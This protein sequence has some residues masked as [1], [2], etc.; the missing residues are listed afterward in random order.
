MQ[1]YSVPSG[2]YLTGAQ[3][4]VENV[5]NIYDTAVQTGFKVDDVIKQSNANDAVKKAASARRNASVAKQAT[6]S[7][8]NL[9]QSD[10][11]EKASKKIDET[12]RPAKRMAG[13]AAATTS[14][15]Q[16]YLQMQENKLRQKEQAEIR[17]EQKRVNDAIIA[18]EEARRK[19]AEADR[20]LTEKKLAE[21]NG[22][23]SDLLSKSDN[24]SSLS[25]TPSVSSTTSRLFQPIEF[26]GSGRLS[27]EQVKTLALNSGF[28]DAESDIVVKIAR[29][30][31]SFNPK[32]HNDD[33]S[34]GDNSFG[35]MQINMLGNLGPAR[36]KQFGIESNDALFD[37]QTNMNAAYQVY[38]ERGS[39]EPWTVY[40][41]LKA[42]GEL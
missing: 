8:A 3:S 27:K 33:S 6:Q 31:S 5:T 42:R 40:R 22:N 18:S 9:K 37:P 30:E 36:R 34:T 7:F 13:V 17:A 15:S 20:K 10:I 39:F 24:T 28:T 14:F 26:Q 38:K 16:G 32:A 35:L 2:N 12:M 21:L 19:E 25:T 23:T 4:V 1:F 11:V 29:G 41:N